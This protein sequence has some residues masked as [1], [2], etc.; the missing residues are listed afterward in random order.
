MVAN[1]VPP[2]PK[3]VVIVNIRKDLAEIFMEKLLKV[4]I[5]VLSSS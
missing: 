5:A 2:H 4:L 1:V 3:P